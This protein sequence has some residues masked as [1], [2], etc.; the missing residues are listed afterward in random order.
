MSAAFAMF[1][2]NPVCLRLR[3]AFRRLVA[4][5]LRRRLLPVFC[6][7]RSNRRETPRSGQE[8]YPAPRLPITTNSC[9][10]RGRAWMPPRLGHRA[11]VPQ[12]ATEWKLFGLIRKDW[13]CSDNGVSTMIC[14]TAIGLVAAGVALAFGLAT[15]ADATVTSLGVSPENSRIVKVAEGCGPGR[16][17]G[18][19]GACHPFAISRRCP[20]GY[21][22]GPHGRRC[23]PD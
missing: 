5:G 16:W 22:I 6:P 12:A 20:V 3:K 23:W 13:G 17:R 21:H 4:C 1:T 9:V 11:T 7:C 18:P 19:A 10:R 15:A 2:T 8:S 14:K